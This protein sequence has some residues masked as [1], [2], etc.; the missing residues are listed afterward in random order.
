M[1][2]IRLED[3]IRCQ[4]C[5]ELSDLKELSERGQCGFCGYRFEVEEI[6]DEDYNLEN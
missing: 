2:Y 3:Q 6:T 4:E 1:G 5:G